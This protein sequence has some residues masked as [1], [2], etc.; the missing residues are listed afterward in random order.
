M[1][2][3]FNLKKRLKLPF[4]MIWMNLDGIMLSKIKPDME[5]KMLHD[6]T[7]MC[8]LKTSQVYRNSRMVVIRDKD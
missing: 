1:Y 7:S 2:I 6:L 8:Y 3:V 4:L 5:R